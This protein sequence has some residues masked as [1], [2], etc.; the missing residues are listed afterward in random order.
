MQKLRLDPAPLL[1]RHHLPDAAAQLGDFMLSARDVHE[2]VEEATSLAPPGTLS[3]IAGLH[4]ADH[5]PNPFREGTHHAVNLL[6]AIHRH[7]ALVPRYGP[8]ARFAVRINGHEVCWRKATRSPMAETEIFC[9]ANLIGHVRAFTHP[10]WLPTSVAVAV[11]TPEALSN[12]PALAG[13][14]VVSSR[15]DGTHIHFRISDVWR[16]PARSGGPVDRL[17]P[18]N[19]DEPDFIESLRLL[20]QGYA[21][22]GTLSL[23][24]T[25]RAARL[26]VRTLQRRLKEAGV[27]H[28]TLADQA[29]F[30]VAQDLL[31]TA[32]DLSITEIAF[33][34]GYSDPGSFSRAFRRFAGIPP[35]DYRRERLAD[36]N[37]TVA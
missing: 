19:A 13:M 18:S 27:S 7:N 24:E 12:Q 15:D 29:R 6:D 25:A 10:R 36:L 4:N 33:E 32:R 28:A 22:T 23:D 31:T 34:L 16:K 9:V 8:G 11:A 2:F 3:T 17:Q 1:A 35:Q 5:Q 30:A 21:R 37:R 14:A 20:M 26:S